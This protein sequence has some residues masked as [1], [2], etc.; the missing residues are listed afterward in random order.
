VQEMA[1]Y[2]GV[3]RSSVSN[4]INGRVQPSTPALRLWA[5]RCGVSY[6]WLAGGPSPH[7]RAGGV[8][9]APGLRKPGIRAP[10]TLAA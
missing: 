9:T 10:Y 6:E 5:M 2:L 3:A 8:T 1:D 4:W 7:A